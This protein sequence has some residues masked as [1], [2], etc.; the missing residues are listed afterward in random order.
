MTSLTDIDGVGPSYAEDL[1]DEGYESAEDVAD[2]DPDA[3][4]DIIPTATGEEI[5]SNAQ[6]E[7][8]LGTPESEST[9]EET[10]EDE[11]EAES[12]DTEEAVEENEDD[13]AEV[14]T[15][16]PGFSEDQEHHLITA[17]VNEEITS[18]RR[19]NTDRLED[20]RGAIRQIRQGEPYE[21]TLKQLSIAYTGSNQLESE[22]RGTRGLAS[23]VSQIR[24]VSSYFQQ[25]RQ[26]NWP[27]SE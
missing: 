7:A 15:L 20:A 11:A 17:L 19:N 14:F 16:E 5:V 2:A 27:E 3:L 23:F 21:L 6:D 24:D 10:V 13:G 12:E 1:E 8:A 9:A 4:D 18:R 25:A 26:E 22:Y